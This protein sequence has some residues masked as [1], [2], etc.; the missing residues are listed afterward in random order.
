MRYET[1]HEFPVRSRAFFRSYDHCTGH[2]ATDARTKKRFIFHLRRFAHY[3]TGKISKTLLSASD[4]FCCMNTSLYQSS[5][6]VT[7]DICLIPEQCAVRS[8]NR[9]LSLTRTEY[10]LFCAL[11]LRPN[12]VLSRAQLQQ[13]IWGDTLTG[14][15]CI[16]VN[17]S[18]LRSKFNGCSFPIRSVRGRGYVFR[19]NN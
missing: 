19:T 6:F 18:R 2:H 3:P 5:H 16:D 14:E 13:V 17:L 9:T 7:T 8:G 15:R 4:G 10:A 12:T 11:A 1:K